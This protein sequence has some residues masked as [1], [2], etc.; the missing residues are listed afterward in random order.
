MAEE[1]EPPSPTSVSEIIPTAVAAE[2]EMDEYKRLTSELLLAL[3]DYEPARQLRS[4][5]DHFDNLPTLPP[6]FTEPPPSIETPIDG[7][8]TKAKK[9]RSKKK[10]SKGKGKN[11]RGPAFPPVE[12]EETTTFATDLEPEPVVD[13]QVDELAKFVQDHMHLAEPVEDVVDDSDGYATITVFDTTTAQLGPNDILVAGEW[14]Y[15][16]N[17]QGGVV[18]ISLLEIDGKE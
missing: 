10:K 15:T 18:R 2:A 17:P 7:W 12:R 3:G 11:P 8:K 5:I 1:R 4:A 9:K 14:L 16:R 13:P 6:P